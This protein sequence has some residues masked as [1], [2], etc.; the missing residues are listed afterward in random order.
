ME[1]ADSEARIHDSEA[2]NSCKRNAFAIHALLVRQ[3]AF[4][5]HKKFTTL[6]IYA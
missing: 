5:I 1:R 2:V 3:K 4:A 6:V